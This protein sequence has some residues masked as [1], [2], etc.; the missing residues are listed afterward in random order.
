MNRSEFLQQ[1]REALENDLSGK[2]I[3]ENVDYYNSYITEE[4]RNGQTEKSVLDM[5]GDPWIIA[6]T[7]IDSSKAESGEHVYEPQNNGYQQESDFNSGKIHQFELNTWW[8][9]LLLMLAIMGII[10]VVMAIFSGIISLA[11][12]LII[13]ILIIVFI[14]RIFRNR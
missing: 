9:K 8:K 5:L 1:L 7:I 6:R 3:Q 2:V 11:A 14:L 10:C 4:V 13:P 12:P